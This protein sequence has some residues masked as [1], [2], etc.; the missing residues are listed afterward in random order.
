M[1]SDDPLAIGKPSP[2]V[3]FVPFCE[4]CFGVRVKVIAPVIRII[5]GQKVILDTDL[6]RIYLQR[7]AAFGT[8]AWEELPGGVSGTNAL[9]PFVDAGATNA[10]NFY[11]V[12]VGQ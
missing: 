8:G 6:A 3:V 5:R 4:S 9:L 12:R 10:Q 11:R 7:C 2:F 1:L